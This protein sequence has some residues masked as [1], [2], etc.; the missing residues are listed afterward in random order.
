MKHWIAKGQYWQKADP[1]RHLQCVV[2]CD[3]IC[4]GRWIFV[5]GSNKDVPERT[6]KK[7]GISKVFR[8]GNMC[9]HGW[10]KGRCGD[11][12]AA[13]SAATPSRKRLIT[14]CRKSRLYTWKMI[15]LDLY[16]RW[17]AI[18]MINP[19]VR[20]HPSIPARLNIAAGMTRSWGQTLIIS[21]SFL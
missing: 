11:K 15:D 12:A 1:N 4:Y 19:R 20:H 7:I 14:A 21:F 16:W 5:I 6:R 17:T 13:S 10:P 3:K 9:F 18:V 8:D 2:F